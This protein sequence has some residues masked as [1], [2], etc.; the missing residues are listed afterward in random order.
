MLRSLY[1]DLSAMLLD[2]G[3]DKTVRA[4]STLSK[5]L[6]RTV[7]RMPDRVRKPVSCK[8]VISALPHFPNESN[9]ST[10]SVY[11]HVDN[12]GNNEGSY[13]VYDSRSTRILELYYYRCGRMHGPSFTW[14]RNGIIASVM[15]WKNGSS[16]GYW[17]RYDKE[18]NIIGSG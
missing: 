18:G 12:Y 17:V 16:C 15:M 6:H 14:N 10:K 4:F 2:Q 9:N 8:V 3:H 7:M 11:Y 1:Y 13:Q 5:S